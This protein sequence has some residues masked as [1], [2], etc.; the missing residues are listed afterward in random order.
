M[1]NYSVLAKYYDK[2]SQNDCDYESWSQYLCAVA[3]KYN[4]KT[5]ADIAC[6]TG[7]MT[8]LL[9]KSGY[10]VV[11]LDASA[12]MLAQA[13]QKC[14]ANFVL[15]DM[16]KLAF[17]RPVDMAVIVNDGLNYLR[18]EELAPFFTNL[19]QN[20]KKGALLVFDVSTPYKLNSVLGNNV[21]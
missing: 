17:T 15:Q 16:R 14:R 10:S 2:F 6:G 3:K 8:A 1:K 9:V 7:K 18:P 4:V 19:A 21:F 20:L 5:I 13:A 12:E 11:G